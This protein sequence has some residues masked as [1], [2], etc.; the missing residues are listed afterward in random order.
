M[1]GA[2]APRDRRIFAR[3]YAISCLIRSPAR[4]RTTTRNRAS[5]RAARRPRH[6]PRR[7]CLVRG[8]GRIL[9][10]RDLLRERGRALEEERQQ[11][12]ARAVKNASSRGHGEQREHP[13]D[14]L[15]AE[16]VR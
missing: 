9:L 3:E 15:L 14:R 6:E 2:L 8:V 13:P 11:E 10:E 16:E 12:R 5:A 1:S 4:S 7:R